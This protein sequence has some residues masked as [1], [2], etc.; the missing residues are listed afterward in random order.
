MTNRTAKLY[1]RSKSGYRKPGKRLSDLPEGETFQLF[2]YEGTKK[3]AKAVGRFADEAQVALITKE[4]ELRKLAVTGTDPLAVAP[5][6]EPEHPRKVTV[7][8]DAVRDYMENV[9]GRIGHD[10]YGASPRTLQAYKCRLGYLL[11]FDLLEF[12]GTT[13]V[14]AVDK[15]YFERFRTFLRSRVRSDRYAHN[16]LQAVNIFFR[17]LGIESCAPVMREA[18]MGA[19]KKVEAY[20]PEQLNRFFLECSPEEALIFKTF[21]HTMGREREVAHTEVAD[22]LFAESNCWIQPKPHRRFRLKG[23]KSGQAARGRKVPIPRQFMAA[24]KTYCEGKQPHDLLFPNTEGRVEGHFL[25]KCQR[26][27]KRAGLDPKDFGLHKFR[28]TG[29]TLHYKAGV[30]V[31]II[32]VWLGHENIAVTMAYLDISDAA[33]EHHVDLVSNGACSI[34]T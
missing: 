25:A 16:I 27:A 10:G 31:P 26:I 11:E 8:R 22:L 14:K 19:P 21:L 33:D 1:I 3:K 4:S 2:W 32:S 9:R 34:W 20:K 30:P 18:G 28:K 23:K 17:T 7:V 5:E 6:S 29:A 24:L 15:R 13:P 12:D